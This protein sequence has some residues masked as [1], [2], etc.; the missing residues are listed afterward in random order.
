MDGEAK[1]GLERS[2]QAQAHGCGRPA[3]EATG[4]PSNR[5]TGNQSLSSGRCRA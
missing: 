4:E 3:P 1:E 5:L 2:D